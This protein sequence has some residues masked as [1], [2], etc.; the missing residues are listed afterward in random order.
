[1]LEPRETDIPVLLLVLVV[2]PLVTYFLLG[3]WNEAAK[4]KERIS[5]IAQRAV[6]E[7]LVVEDMAAAS[8]IPLMPLPNIGSNQCARCYGPAKTRCSWCKSARYWYVLKL[9]I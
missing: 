6:E 3:K 4:N 2:L 8:F 9:L 5:S 7:A 1:M